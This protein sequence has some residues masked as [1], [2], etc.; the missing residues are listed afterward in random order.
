MGRRD[1]VAEAV[2]DREERL[3]YKDREASSYS[4]SEEVLALVIRLSLFY[5]YT[6]TLCTATC[7]CGGGSR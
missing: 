3:L 7:I 6:E 4:I 2:I 1:G 5:A